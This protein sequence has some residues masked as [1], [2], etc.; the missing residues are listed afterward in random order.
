MSAS[1]RN[2]KT[3]IDRT[4]QLFLDMVY[5]D[6]RTEVG[7]DQAKTL[8]R[9]ALKREQQIMKERCLTIVND[10]VISNNS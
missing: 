6:F 8:I 3:L 4:D 9:R 10:I 2:E 5:T 7:R 1:E